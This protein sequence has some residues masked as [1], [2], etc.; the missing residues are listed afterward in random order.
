MQSHERFEELCVLAAAGEISSVDQRELIAHM[1]E[2]RACRNTFEDMKEIHATWLPERPG[3]EMQGRLAAQLRLRQSI[4]GRATVEGA[5]FSAKAWS[6]EPA[7][8]NGLRP[9]Y[10][11]FLRA[12]LG[13]AAVVLIVL[14]GVAVSGH[15]NFRHSTSKSSV[16]AQESGAAG[17]DL[18]AA[19]AK[20]L[21][22]NAREALASQERL[23]TA[24]KRA[25]LD[26]EHAEE[27]VQEA[28]RRASTFEQSNS[29][30]TQELAALREQLDSAHASEQRAEDQLAVFKAAAS[31]KE[32]QLLV[33][34]EENKEL[35]N[36]LA[37]QATGVDR[38]RELMADGREIRDLI[39][40]RNLHIIDVY[41][42][43][44][45]GKTQQ[46]FGRVFYTEG[47]SLVFY[48]YDLPARRADAKYA[49]YAWGKRDASEQGVRN[50]GIFY[51]D[52]QTQR[53]WV[54]NVTDPQIL[55]EIDSVFVTLEPSD[56]AG[57]RPSGK[58][59]LSAFLGTPPN[60]P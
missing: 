29:A 30:S 35:R 58:K 24:L 6:P 54:L 13:V 50:L 5:H 17:Q 42:T 10:R 9:R 53:R 31:D 44:G 45:E 19:E 36:K 52:D 21:A 28:E 26:K 55:S 33:A 1:E 18:G 27:R 20:R 56:H 3:F 8:S 4:L 14:G 49:F 11:Q 57:S 15:V 51:S 48:A 40:A 37:V 23:E 43:N 32:G 59:L 12:A 47:K 60:H 2:C 22:A 41:D 38:E 25:E 34:E 16:T 46:S 39:A 7:V